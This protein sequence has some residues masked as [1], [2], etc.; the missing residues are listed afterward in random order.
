MMDRRQAMMRLAGAFG[1]GISFLPRAVRAQ[2]HTHSRRVAV[3]MAYA[4]NDAEGQMRVAALRAELATTPGTAIELDVRW[5]AGDVGRARAMAT[6]I[7]ALAP[8]VIVVNG[9]PGLA[10]VKPLTRTIPI[11]FVV[12]VDPVDAGFIQSFARPGGNITGF[13]TF[14]PEIVGKWVQLL[15]E[16]APN[17]KRVGV[18]TDP[19]VGSFRRFWTFAEE[20]ARRHG[21][22]AVPIHVRSRADIEST[23]EA[24]AQQPNVGLIVLPPPVNS[25]NRDFIIAV[26][27]RYRLPAIYPFAFHAREGG[28]MAYGFDA[29]VQFRRSATYVMRILAGE[30]PADLPA[31]APTRFELVINLK[32]AAALGITI[33]PSI[34]IRADEVIE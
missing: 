10:A 17:I 31:Q 24:F 20:A 27:G 34:L 13:T 14:E 4:D 5:Y 2:A 8:D 26:T 32:T 23:L 6:E 9:S 22:E 33:P 7:I 19:D 11:V 25:V 28:L 1:G 21:L 16:V 18:L 30:K 12:V 29:A 15:S 3:L